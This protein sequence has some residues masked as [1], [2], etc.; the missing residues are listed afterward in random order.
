MN[1]EKERN[2]ETGRKTMGKNCILF[3]FLLSCI[4]IRHIIFVRTKISH[5]QKEPNLILYMWVVR[6]KVIIIKTWETI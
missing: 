1:R 4:L 2:W 6:N 3:L 5:S